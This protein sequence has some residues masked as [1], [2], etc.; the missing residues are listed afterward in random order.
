[1]FGLRLRRFRRVCQSANLI[2]RALQLRALIAR[3]SQ[4]ENESYVFGVENFVVRFRAQKESATARLDAMWK[5]KEYQCLEN[6]K[7]GAP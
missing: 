5:S 2:K 3:P 1:M 6:K 7:R 4:R